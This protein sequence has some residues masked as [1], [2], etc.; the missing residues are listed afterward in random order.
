MLLTDKKSELKEKEQEWL[1]ED[2][3][4]NCENGSVEETGRGKRSRK[5]KVSS[6]DALEP[7]VDN[8][9]Q[10]TATQVARKMKQVM[11]FS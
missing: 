2:D 8:K 1:Q 10:K 3:G 5:P 9:T 7:A 4:S 6:L 11:I